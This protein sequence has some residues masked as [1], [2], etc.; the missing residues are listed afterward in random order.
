[1]WRQMQSGEGKDETQ[2]SYD[3][4]KEP[5]PFGMDMVG[6]DGT[7]PE[8]VPLV[9]SQ[10]GEFEDKSAYKSPATM[11]PQ[12]DS[13]GT[14]GHGRMSVV[15]DPQSISQIEIEEDQSGSATVE[16]S[17]NGEHNANDKWS[18]E[19][20]WMASVVVKVEAVA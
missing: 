4:D 17:S 9:D 2:V 12:E 6:K 16:G 19:G 11:S 15:T 13:D 8:F 20:S 10:C 7:D 5:G 18:D 14:D 1:M 3:H